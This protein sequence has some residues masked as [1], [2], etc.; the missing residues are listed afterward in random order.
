MAD[1]DSA[2]FARD[3]DQLLYDSGAGHGCAE[4]VFI[5][6]D[7]A[8]LYAGHNEVLGKIIIDVLDI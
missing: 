3:L 5:F 1:R 6:I 7:S 4:Q 8:C 2:F